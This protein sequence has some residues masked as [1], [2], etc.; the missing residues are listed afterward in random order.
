M[1]LIIAAGVGITVTLIALSAHS[2]KLIPSISQYY[3]DTVATEAG[4]RKY[5]QRYSRGLPWI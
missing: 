4:G 3:K 1:N 2:Q 5:R